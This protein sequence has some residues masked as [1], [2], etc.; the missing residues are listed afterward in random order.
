MVKL[1]NPV[2]TR[3][4]GGHWGGPV[5]MIFEDGLVKKPAGDQEIAFYRTVAQSTLMPRFHGTEK[6]R[7]QVSDTDA[8]GVEYVVLD[9]VTAGF[10]KPCVLDV[11]IGRS[12]WFEGC[13][14][15]KKRRCEEIDRST[16]SSKYGFKLTGMRTKDPAT[17]EDHDYP[18]DVAWHMTTDTQLLGVFREFFSCCP[19][20]RLGETVSFF[21]DHVKAAAEFVKR[22]RLELRSS[23][24]LFVYDADSR[25]GK[26]PEVVMI[27]FAH[28]RKLSN[29]EGIDEGYIFGCSELSRLL[30][31]LKD[32]FEPIE[33]G[34]VQE[35]KVTDT[36]D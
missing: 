8:R 32:A 28:T 7:V 3:Q 16:T 17:G 26:C 12:T 20:Q 34:E 25:S 6:R 35:G 13:T 30:Q 18:R 36:S 21:C 24:L 10:I 23:S 31:Q 2:G 5:G 27:D 29:I 19:Q 22:E 14:A 11:K 33:K 15:D 1:T 4:V 9:D